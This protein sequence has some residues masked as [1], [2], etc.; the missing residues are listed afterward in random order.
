MRT[1][2][3]VRTCAVLV[4]LPLTVGCGASLRQSADGAPALPFAE[5]PPVRGQRDILTGAEI[6]SAGAITAR[7]AVTWLRPQFL[8][9][10]G[11]VTIQDSYGGLP[12]VCVDGM[13]LGGPEVLSTIPAATIVEIRYL[14][15]VTADQWLGRYHPGGVIAIR[16]R[17]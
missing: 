1:P 17:P 5:Q 14:T 13:C 9:R 4:T 15:A 12:A 7:D 10:R 6:R 2:R 11:A 3:S 16:T 8:T